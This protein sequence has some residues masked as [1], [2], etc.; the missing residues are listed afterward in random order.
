MTVSLTARLVSAEAGG[1]EEDI[2]KM[3]ETLAPLGP[4]DKPAGPVAELLAT[5]V[6]LSVLFYPALICA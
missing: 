6:N 1:V 5:A 2:E 3:I 4:E